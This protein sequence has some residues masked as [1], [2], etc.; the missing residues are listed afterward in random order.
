MFINEDYFNDI[1][2]NADDIKANDITDS[3]NSH[4]P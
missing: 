2:I 3:N 4:I 1:D